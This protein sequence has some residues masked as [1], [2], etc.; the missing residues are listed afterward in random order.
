MAS[1][2]RQAVGPFYLLLC[3]LL[4][5]SAQGIWTTA[6]LQLL[7]LGLIAWAAASGSA[8]PLGR[9]ARYLLWLILAGLAVVAA[10]LIPL[11][12]SLWPHLGGREGI[13]GGYA[14]LGTPVPSL[15]L[16][17]APYETLA[18]ILTLLP[19]LGLL[20]AM[21]VLK[22]YRPLW[23]VL[24]LLAGTFAGIL[25]GA[26]QVAD[27]NPMSSWYLYR[28]VSIGVATGFFANA[29]HM[30]LLLVITIPFLAALLAA[31]RGANVQRYSAA[32]ALVAGA[33]LVVVVGIA[34]NRSLAGYGLAVPVLALSALIVL[35]ARTALRRWIGVT[36]AL[37]FLGAAVALATRPV[38]DVDFGASTSV[39]S[40]AAILATAT[41]AISDFLPFGS[42]LGTF[43]EVYKLYEDHDAVIPVVINH[44]HNDYAELALE[45]GVP[46]MLVL[47]AFL[48]WWAVAA[49]RVWRS[50]DA[51]PYAKAASIASAAILIHSLVDFPLR[52]SAVAACFAMCL[53]LLVERRARPAAERADFRPTRHIVLE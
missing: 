9:P 17:V 37:L 20:C 25:L 8:E 18:T 12:P 26:L 3:L 2:V 29:N 53:A 21:I 30:A 16:S 13:A 10:Q 51:G 14:I 45:T 24:T 4:G 11:P 50:A 48:V 40:R 44:A 46:G 35:P 19:P 34:L 7:G 49:A 38:D 52:T 22:A 43:R 42:G 5:G 15:P 31:A 39:H 1:S 27:P 41:D 36:A 32:V 23:L 28:Q 47:A 6:L 33:V